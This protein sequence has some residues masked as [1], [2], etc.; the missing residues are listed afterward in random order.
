MLRCGLA[1]G[2][3]LNTWHLSAALFPALLGLSTLLP[4]E[5]QSLFRGTPLLSIAVVTLYGQQRIQD[6]QQS[7]QRRQLLAFAD[8]AA[9]LFRAEGDRSWRHLGSLLI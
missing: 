4:Q 7:E 6:E 8:R 1:Q 9:D 2:A 3:L 5:L